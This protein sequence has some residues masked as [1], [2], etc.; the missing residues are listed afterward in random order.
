MMHDKG[1]RLDDEIRE[2]FVVPN[3]DLEDMILKRGRLEP[4]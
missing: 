4:I 3:L 1:I 2:G